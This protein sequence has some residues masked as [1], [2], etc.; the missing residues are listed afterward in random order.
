MRC[1]VT[2]KA[3]EEVNEDG[4]RFD[5]QLLVV[6]SLVEIEVV[7]EDGEFVWGSEVVV[8]DRETDPKDIARDA[9]S[10]AGFVDTELPDE[11]R[12]GPAVVPK[13]ASI[14]VTGETERLF[15]MAVAIEDGSPSV[16]FD[17]DA[18]GGEPVQADYL[19]EHMGEGHLAVE[20]DVSGNGWYVERPD[21][22]WV[23]DDG[24]TYG[25]YFAPL[26]S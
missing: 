16:Q 1:K 8:S 20:A 18:A 26:A 11:W 7:D 10:A 21:A 17:I 19:A 15:Q 25:L 2:I 12:P 14:V 9:L 5:P 3:V 6:G 24:R 22:Y 23:C 4:E 13:C